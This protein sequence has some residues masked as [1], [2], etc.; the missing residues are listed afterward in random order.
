LIN[1]CMIGIPQ[2]L[3]SMLKQEYKWMSKVEV[4]NQ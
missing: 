4:L 3:N 1:L 2:L